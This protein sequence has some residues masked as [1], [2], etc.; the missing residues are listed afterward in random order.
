MYTRTHAHI[1]MHTL[2]HM[3]TRTH[4][5]T[6]AHVHTQERARKHTHTFTLMLG[7]RLCGRGPPCVERDRIIEWFPMIRTQVFNSTSKFL[8][9]GEP[10]RTEDFLRS[11]HTRTNTHTHTHTHAHMHIHIPT[12]MHSSP[13]FH[14]LCYICFG[15]FWS[16]YT[17]LAVYCKNCHTLQ[18]TATHHNT[19]QHTATHGNTRQ[20]T[21]THEQRSE[22]TCNTMQHNVIHCKTMQHMATYT[23]HCIT[24]CCI[25]CADN[26]CGENASASWRRRSSENRDA[27]TL[28]LFPASNLHRFTYLCS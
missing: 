11:T 19:R 23:T 14:V 2:T 17:L 15:F 24:A 5:H 22:T 27:W 21:A 12:R 1:Y 26:E 20:H 18:Q 28:S 7:T 16:S 9:F 13:Y 4:A 8:L 3:H 6:H 25:Y 10:F